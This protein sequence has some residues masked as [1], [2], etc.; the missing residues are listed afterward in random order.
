MIMKRTAFDWTRLLR[1]MVAL[2]VIMSMLLCGCASAGGDDDD[3]EGGKKNEGTSEDGGLL[4]GDGDGKLEAE[5]VVDNVSG[6]YGNLLG[7]VGGDKNS[8]TNGGYSLSM[9]VTLGDSIL[10]Q[11]S[12]MLEYEGLDADISWFKSLGFVMEVLYNENLSQVNMEAKLNGTGI[13]SV[14]AVGDL[15]AASVFLRIPELSSQYVGGAVDMDMD[16]EDFVEQ[17]NEILAQME[18]YGDVVNALPTEEALNTLLNRYVDAA[19]KALGEPTTA[20]E[21]LTTGGLSVEV[22]AS[23]YTI[24]SSTVINVV[25]AMLNTAKTDAELETVLDNFGTWYNEMAA[26]EYEEMGSTWEEIDLHA[27]LM[28]AVDEGLAAMAEARAELENGDT[29]D[30][31]MLT[32]SNYLVGEESVGF[33][34]SVNGGYESTSVY[35]YNLEQDGK[36]AFELNMADTMVFAGTGTTDGSKV[37]GS[38]ALSTYG[39]EMFY[40]DVVDF[41]TK[42]LDKG[43]LKGTLRLRFSEEMLYNSY[44]SFLTPETVIELGF[45]MG[46]GKTNLVVTLLNGEDMI[47]SVALSTKALSGKVSLPGS[48]A[49]INDGTAM[50]NW[51]AGMS[52]DKVLSNLRSAGVSSEL[53]DMLE[54]ALDQAMGG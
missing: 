42:A 37:N 49:D 6:I 12:Q 2:L 31:E 9:D 21:T 13:L 51:V 11:F 45:D 3:D 35:M 28:E 50:Q 4:K 47:F 52:F 14:E 25:E 26:K 8:L 1:T 19:K 38:Y 33:A 20:T 39:E 53:V 23:T 32:F 18:E 29:E 54:E 36:T 46:G 7:L 17:Y 43:E 34:L 22:T 48:Y 27:Q 40:I 15:M 5:D 16:M 10:E 44:N 24:H 41:D 30:M